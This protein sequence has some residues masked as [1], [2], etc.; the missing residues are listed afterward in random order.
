MP[1][2]N[3]MCPP[4]VAH[5]DMGAYAPACGGGGC[6]DGMSLAEVTDRHRAMVAMSGGGPAADAGGYGRGEPP[7]R[8]APAAPASGGSSASEDA[9]WTRFRQA[10]V[11]FAKPLLR[12]PYERNEISKDGFRSVL[13]KT[14]E[15]VVKSFQREGLPP[16]ANPDI[17]ANQRAKIT[18]LVEEY[19]KLAKRE[20]G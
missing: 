7:S 16:P 8:G 9:L 17:A 13:K 20:E 11:E 6:S 3:G 15:K 14:A 1:C 4:M 2:A 18:K 5:A 19:L 12:G 10:I